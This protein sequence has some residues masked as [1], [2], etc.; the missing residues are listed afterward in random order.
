M[1]AKFYVSGGL[2][3]M[4]FA[5]TWAKRQC[6]QVKSRLLQVWQGERIVWKRKERGCYKE[7]GEGGL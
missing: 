1:N 2:L 7:L 3:G 4:A 6:G 5:S